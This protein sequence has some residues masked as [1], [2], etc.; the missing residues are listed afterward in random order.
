MNSIC[1]VNNE[2]E[3]INKVIFAKP[4]LLL[5]NKGAF[6]IYYCFHGTVIFVTVQLLLRVKCDRLW[7]LVQQ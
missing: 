1:D 3:S 7:A 2:D 4:A 6:K 5:R